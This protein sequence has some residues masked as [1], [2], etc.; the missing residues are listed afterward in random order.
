MDNIIK[1]ISNMF[2]ARYGTQL[3]IE[4]SLPEKKAQ[5]LFL[6]HWRNSFVYSQTLRQVSFP[7]F[8]SKSELRAIAVASPVEN[9]D[10]VVFDEMAQF[11]QLT[12]AEHL[13]LT[14]KKELQ[15]ETESAL[16]RAHQDEHSNV[17]SLKTK[18]VI[19]T[20][21]EWKKRKAPKEYD[22][23]PIWLNGLK[24]NF[25]S[26]LA[27]SVHD[28][29]SNWAFINAKEIP[30]LI[31]KDPNSWQNFP[32]VTIY[33]PKIETLSHENLMILKKNLLE[34]R[35]VKGKK[36]L[37]I[38]SSTGLLSPEA[39]ALKNLFK[40]YEVKEN[41]SAQVQAHFL[42]YRHRDIKP[43]NYLCAK[44]ESLFFLPFSTPSKEFH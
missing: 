32:Q 3:K 30:D 27:F 35:S 39:E 6:S 22:H 44:S 42:L 33:I 26:H 19:A 5:P 36:P 20:P 8:N 25:N 12:I 18:N 41:I 21:I 17:I 37:I 29:I 11:L 34:L 2:M 10:A 16:L 4:T 24:D 7:I 28:W 31:W 15:N 43:W 38:V 23:E 14:Q 9:K 40:Y 1:T 13:E